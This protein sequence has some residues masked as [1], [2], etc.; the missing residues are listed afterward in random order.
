MEYQLTCYLKSKVVN[1][2][3]LF[4]KGFGES[5]LVIDCGCDEKT[6]SEEEHQMN[7]RTEFVVVK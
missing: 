4:S 6:C 5:L 7:R 3:R 2:R 1:P